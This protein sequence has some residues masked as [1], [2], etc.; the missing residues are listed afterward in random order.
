MFLFFFSCPRNKTDLQDT[1]RSYN[2]T[3]PDKNKNHN[4]SLEKEKEKE[5]E[6]ESGQAE[7]EEVKA[8]P[9]SAKGQK[10]HKSKPGFDPSRSGT[11]VLLSK[12]ID[13]SPDFSYRKEARVGSKATGVAKFFPNPEGFWGP[14]SRATKR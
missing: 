8:A 1:I 13:F 9:A 4:A 7:A 10:T 2:L 3:R 11:G 6:K 12:P 5:K 14:K